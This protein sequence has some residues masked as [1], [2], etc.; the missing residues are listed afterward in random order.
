MQLAMLAVSP[1]FHTTTQELPL[2][3]CMEGSFVCLSCMHL[4]DCSSALVPVG[5]FRIV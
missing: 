5:T 4:Q 1:L 2:W 3:A